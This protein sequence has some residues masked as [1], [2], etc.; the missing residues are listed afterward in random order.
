MKIRNFTMAG[1][2]CP[3]CGNIQEK[4]LNIFDFS[5]NERFDISCDSCR[6]TIASLKKTDR[7]KYKFNLPCIECGSGHT[8]T[9]AV[10]EF[11]QTSL[12]EFK[13]MQTEDVIFVIG[14]ADKVKDAINDAFYLVP[15]DNSET[16][17]DI[18][19]ISAID[20]EQLFDLVRHLEELSQCGMIHCSCND[21]LI[22]LQIEENGIRLSCSICDDE[23]FFEILSF[24]DVKKIKGLTEIFLD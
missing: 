5:G 19:P 9:I 17:Y 24:E 11:W 18:F 1:F 16:E 2:Q 23:L 21:P 8:Y 22:Q 12:K 3:H 20:S 10:N 13:C 7:S 15:C 6:K 4:R 14:N